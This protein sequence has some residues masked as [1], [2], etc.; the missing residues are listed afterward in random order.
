MMNLLNDFRETVL[1]CAEEHYDTVMTIYT[2][3]QPAQPVTFG[4][5]LAER[6]LP[7]K[8]ILS[9]CGMR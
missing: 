8:G 7:W 4:Y 2:H 9:G 3:S 5:Y 6:R 1:R